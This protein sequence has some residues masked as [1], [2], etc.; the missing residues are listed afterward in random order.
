LA[1]GT[2]LLIGQQVRA[3][4]SG[5]RTQAFVGG[6][7][8]TLRSREEAT[9]IRDSCTFVVVDVDGLELVVDPVAAPADPPTSS[10]IRTPDEKLENPT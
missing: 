8:W 1:T 5:H 3:I 7:W 10:Q 4:V 6:A 2:G 9:P